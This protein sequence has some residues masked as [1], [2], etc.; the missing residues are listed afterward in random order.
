MKPIFGERAVG[1]LSSTGRLLIVLSAARSVTI[2][3]GLA[4]VPLARALCAN[5]VASENQLPGDRPTD[6]EVNGVG[7]PSIQ[8]YAT[9]MSVNVGQTQ[10]FKVNTPSTN[11]HIDI[12]RLGYCGGDGGRKVASSWSWGSPERCSGF[13]GVFGCARVVRWLSLRD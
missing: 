8:G 9:S 7:D 2:L 13:N 10:W 11:Y 1:E 4:G 5:P 12:L 6:W 3:Q